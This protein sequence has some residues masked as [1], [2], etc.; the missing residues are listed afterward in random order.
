M[1]SFRGFFLG[2]MCGIILPLTL[3]S[4]DPAIQQASAFPKALEI[5]A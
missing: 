4:E 1:S 5:E 2:G 3:R